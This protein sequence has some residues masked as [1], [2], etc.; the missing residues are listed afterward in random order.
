LKVLIG[1]S[2]GRKLDPHFM[3][4]YHVT[5]L[6]VTDAVWKDFKK[7]YH[8]QDHADAFCRK[9]IRGVVVKV[10]RVRSSQYHPT[11]FD[12]EID[13]YRAKQYIA[14][15]SI[16]DS[17]SHLHPENQIVQLSRLENILVI[18]NISQILT[19]FTKTVHT[20][21]NS[22]NAQW[23]CGL[24]LSEAYLASA[25]QPFLSLIDRCLKRMAY[26]H[27]SS[28]PTRQKVFSIARQVLISEGVKPKL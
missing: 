13:Q 21:A 24:Y 26:L 5:H 6:A 1:E 11:L 8:L 2:T 9:W 16:A 14:A 10:Y 28:A 27:P 20:Y 15:L 25:H 18:G 17:L 7:F 19:E 12:T 23:T 4:K 22:Y 3:E